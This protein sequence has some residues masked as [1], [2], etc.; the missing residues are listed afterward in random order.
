MMD[1]VASGCFIALAAVALLLLIAV[2]GYDSTKA[3][4][5]DFWIDGGGQTYY[6]N[7]YR[8]EGGCV[9]FKNHYGNE[10]KQCGNYRISDKR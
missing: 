8:E 2:V 9:Y 1:N 6:T 4:G 3:M 7:S 5:S 10:I